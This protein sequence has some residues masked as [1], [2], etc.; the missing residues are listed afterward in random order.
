VKRHSG[1]LPHSL[2]KR[3]CGTSV[4]ALLLVLAHAA[5]AAVIEAGPEDYRQALGTLQPGDTLRLRSGLYR[6]GLPLHRLSGTA[7]APIVISGPAGS[8]AAVFLARAGHNTVSIVN[9]R[10][11]TVRN[12][13]LDGRNLPVDAVKCEGHAQWAHH[14]ALEKLTI[15]GHG[16]NQQTVGISTK[17]PAWNWVIRD[18][19]IVGA[20]TGIYLGNSDGNAPFVA[21]LIEHNLIVD[22]LG[23]NLQIKHQKPRPELPD[24]PH[25]PSTTIIR[26]NVFSKAH[27]GSDGPM[28]RPNV[29]LGHW[30]LVGAGE[31]DYYQV[32]GN[33]FYDNASEALF[34]GEGNIALH[35]NVFWNPHGDAIHI[36]PHNDVPKQIVVAY[37]TVLAT[38]AGILVRNREGRTQHVQVA[39]ANAVFAAAPIA[40]IKEDNNVSAP[41][42]E[43]EDYLT[44]PFA[45]LGKFDPRPLPG[46]LKLRKDI[47]S[48][49]PAWPGLDVD[50]EGHPYR[51]PLAGAYGSAGGTPGWLPRLEIKPR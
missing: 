23:Y 5:G 49:L 9:A 44:R 21:G 48:A 13:E 10:F 46:R 27:G 12:L 8:P 42:A 15:H 50:F 51:L 47:H 17:C 35:H 14:I 40:G 11:V 3:N 25:E 36:Q 41:L 22:T 31:D 33:F 1:L 4:A 2:L 34:Q 45:P 19:R 24:M 32:Y 18:N 38:G 6:E 16:N 37:N 28:A 29:L 7:E 30:P 20:G 43:A 26:H 39:A